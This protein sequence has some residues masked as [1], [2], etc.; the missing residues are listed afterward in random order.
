MGEV[1]RA[2]D[3][4][5]DYSMESGVKSRE[6]EYLLRCPSGADVFTEVKSPGWEF[7]LT[8]EERSAGRIDQPKYKDGEARA[9]GPWQAIQF[10]VEKA[11]PKFLPNV[12][13]L[14][15]VPKSAHLSQN[16]KTATP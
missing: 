14:L 10:A 6:G 1:Y 8:K 7:E 16:R 12:P 2:E 5:S 11:Y 4:I 15:V 9:V 13:N 3:F